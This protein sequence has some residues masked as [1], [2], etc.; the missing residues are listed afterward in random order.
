MNNFTLS[1]QQKNKV[2][3]S[4]EGSSS[5]AYQTRRL[6]CLHTYRTW[7]NTLRDARQC[8]NLS[9]PCMTSIP[10]WRSRRSSANDDNNR[11]T[12]K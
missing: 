9:T 3:I 6:T 10:N 8:D 1:D 4:F 7:Q 11:S 2:Y 5:K 12:L